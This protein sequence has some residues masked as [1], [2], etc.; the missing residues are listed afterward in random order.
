MDNLAIRKLKVVL[1]DAAT[2]GTAKGTVTLAGC[3]RFFKL[4]ITRV[5]V[6]VFCNAS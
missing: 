1:Y 4:K 2:G 6:D 5:S 3:E